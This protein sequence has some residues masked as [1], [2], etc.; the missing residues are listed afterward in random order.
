MSAIIN[1]ANGAALGLYPISNAK[2]YNLTE[3]VLVWQ[4]GANETISVSTCVVIP[5]EKE[6]E[7]I[8]AIRLVFQ[9]A[10]ES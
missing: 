10:R 6:E 7:L 9:T 8:S 5:L 1:L 2:E 3:G 4:H